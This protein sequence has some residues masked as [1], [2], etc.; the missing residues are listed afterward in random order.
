[1]YTIEILCPES[2]LDIEDVASMLNISLEGTGFKNPPTLLIDTD[3]TCGAMPLQVQFYSYSQ[4]VDGSIV[5][6]QWN[7]G[8]GNT[9]TQP[10][11]S[12]TFMEAGN[13]DACCT[14]TD[15]D[16]LTAYDTISISVNRDKIKIGDQESICQE[17]SFE[18]CFNDGQNRV[19]MYNTSCCPYTSFDFLS[20][21]KIKN[22]TATLRRRAPKSGS[23]T[24]SYWFFGRISGK[25]FDFPEETEFSEEITI[26]EEAFFAVDIDPNK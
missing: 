23:F 4:D 7:F 18:E 20:E 14:V 15:D 22:K 12:Y 8:D 24:Q 16:G 6:Y 11:P 17:S 26:A 9:S 13:H 1:M 19:Y 5:S 10:H 3:K 25:K 2:N 21:L